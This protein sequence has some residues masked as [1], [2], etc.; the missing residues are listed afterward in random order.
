MLTHSETTFPGEL[1]C[2]EGHLLEPECWQDVT[3]NGIFRVANW[4]IP[5]TLTVE[6]LLPPQASLI[7]PSVKVLHMFQCHCP[8]LFSK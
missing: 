6:Q 8:I 5:L 3:S 4:Y 1:E 7:G 2:S